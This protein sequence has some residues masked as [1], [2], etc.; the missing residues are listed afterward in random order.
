[1]TMTMPLIIGDPYPLAF[2]FILI[3]QNVGLTIKSHFILKLNVVRRKVR[4]SMSTD[5]N[6]L[7]K[8]QMC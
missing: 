7:Y 2:D 1:M 3:A 4:K 5:F 6:V 8:F